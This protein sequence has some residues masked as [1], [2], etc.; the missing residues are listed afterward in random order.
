MSV[1][2]VW[3]D[4]NCKFAAYFLRWAEAHPALMAVLNKLP[5][6]LRFPRPVFPRYTSLLPWMSRE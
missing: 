6:K 4:I 5:S 3:Y 2:V 1:L